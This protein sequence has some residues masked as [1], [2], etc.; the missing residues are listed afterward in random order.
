MRKETIVIWIFPIVTCS[1]I[2]IILF[3]IKY[4]RPVTG[5]TVGLIS[6]FVLAL[7]T[8]LIYDD[9]YKFDKL[10]GFKRFDDY[11]IKSFDELIKVPFY[12]FYILLTPLFIYIIRYIK[13]FVI[14]G[15]VVII[16]YL[17]IYAIIKG[18]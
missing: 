10:K 2:F 9:I 7:L 15:I 14:F 3:A 1:L 12:F 5:L 17:I 6:G 4:N 18:L 13:Y 8:K 16:I 11:P